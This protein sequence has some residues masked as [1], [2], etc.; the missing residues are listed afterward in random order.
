MAQVIAIANQ[1]GG[2]G[3]TTTAVN[4]SAS[5]AVGEHKTL[6]ID[7]DPQ[8]NATSGVGLNGRA[9]VFSIYQV[10]LGE[11]TI[12]ETIKDTELSYLKVV[13][14]NAELSGAEVE[15]IEVSE[16][17]YCLRNAI[18]EV[19]DDYE[20]IL[21][22]CPPSLSLLTLNALC[23]S[24][25]VLV[26]LQCEYYALEGMTRLL[27]TLDLVKSRLNPSLELMGIVL[28]MYDQRNNLS[29]QVEEEARKHFGELVFRTV[30]PRNVR[31]GE[32][33]SFGKPI[34]LYDIKSSGAESYLRLAGEFLRKIRG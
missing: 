16:R 12:R 33:P 17:E 15:L 19:K 2:V 5:L 24:E 34:L 27:H 1:K 14:S 7:I 30:I 22:D 9:S 23:S 10:L 29:R 11:V 25:K 28:T 31:L 20:F 26:P 21:V 6:L 32:A 18:E 8:A 3:K 4:L 13:P